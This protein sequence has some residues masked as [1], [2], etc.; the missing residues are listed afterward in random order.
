MLYKFIK[1]IFRI[2]FSTLYPW[3]IRGLD[4][5]PPKGPLIICSNHI[6]WVDPALV[7]SMI[8]RSPVYFMA[9]EELF[10]YIIFGNII[11]GVGAFPV[12]RDSADLKS[13]KKALSL[14]K[15]GAFIAL[16]PEGTRS[17][18]GEVGEALP[19]AAL[20]ALKSEAPVLPIAIRGRYRLFKKIQISIGETMTFPE[21]Y[22]Q[23]A[24][25]ELLANM[26]KTIMSE[27]RR[28]HAGE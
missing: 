6:N 5:I 10:N 4:H 17:K 2:I 11:K 16:F 13:I 20:L 8:P 24:K 26:S 14:L 12:K 3:D 28:L 9:K 15:E 18:T 27:I 19:G 1:A 21:F 25:R 23:K 22:G 7:G